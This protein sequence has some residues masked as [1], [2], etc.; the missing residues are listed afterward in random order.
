M[1]EISFGRILYT[2]CRAGE[3]LGG[4]GG[5]QIQAKSVNVEPAQARMAVNSLTYSIHSSWFAEGLPV[6]RYPLGL[7]HSAEAGFGTAQ[8]RY[9]GAGVNDP[10]PGN[11]LADCLLT[12]NPNNYGSIRPAQLWLSD[13]WIDTP[14]PTT[15]APVFDG[16]LDTGPLDNDF[17]AGWIGAD[18]QRAQVLRS[19]VTVL[20]NPSGP[21]I[22]IRS[23]TPEAALRWIAAATILLPMNQALSTSFRVF[24]STRD[25]ARFRVLGLSSDLVA[26]FT[27]GSRQGVFLLDDEAM[28]SDSV[29]VS[30]RARFWVDLLVCAEEPY[31]V[32]SAVDIAEA[33]SPVGLSDPYKLAD[34]RILAW[35]IADPG[36]NNVDVDA[37]GR[38]LFTASKTAMEKYGAVISGLLVKDERAR[39]RDLG[40]VDGLVST[41]AISLAPGDV[42]L[43][44]IKAEV[45]EAQTLST[46]LDNRLLE[47]PLR[48]TDIREAQTVISSAMV[49]GTDSIIGRLFCVVGR[50]NLTME[51]ISP[52]LAS[53]IHRFVEQWLESPRSFD[54]A[55]FNL[56][57]SFLLDEIHA[58][59]AELLR[60]GKRQKFM[61]ALPVF[62]E[63]ISRIGGD[64]DDE[65]FWQVEACLTSGLAPE[66]RLHR[67]QDVL[68]GPL[69]ASDAESAKASLYQA[70]LVEWRALH[71]ESHLE[72]VATLPLIFKIEPSILSR[73]IEII[74]S[75]I[76]TPSPSILR[77]VVALDRRGA[78]NDS[79]Q[80]GSLAQSVET[81]AT[82]LRGITTTTS[83]PPDRQ[84]IRESL[85]ALSRIPDGVVFSHIPLLTSAVIGDI[86]NVVGAEIVQ[87]LAPRVMRRFMDNW[88][89]TQLSSSEPTQ[90]GSTL[91]WIQNPTVPETIRAELLESLTGMLSELPEADRMKRMDS[92]ASTAME[93][94]PHAWNWV[95][96]A[97][98]PAKKRSP[99][100]RGRN[101]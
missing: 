70:S 76:D 101:K 24:N 66:Q 98:V 55:T 91:S 47:S 35:S 63:A 37:I 64:P 52:E 94:W 62:A 17:L 59:L 95:S 42:R 85:K 87:H 20:E 18:P 77:A 14:W 5:L 32:V 56:Q 34:S 30:D 26:P 65:F 12:A 28:T 3:G 45:R 8:S 51:P 4:G 58:Q 61:S 53:R 44:L 50:H 29:M 75:H 68:A 84:A 23:A 89:R 43:A 1:T 40:V 71:K 7:A 2:D 38:W 99:W 31:D 67:V 6:A 97:L 9:L 83:A 48:D 96:D 25:E 88:L 73:A 69:L 78:F 13:V 49:G 100:R 81:M 10:R 92:I 82:V 11:H 54:Y 36:G 22:F 27:P 19:L 41:G 39:A 90:I 57:D 15:E 80:L 33:L 72:L 21:Q 74:S 79:E 60:T 46:P 16:L 93:L 86:H